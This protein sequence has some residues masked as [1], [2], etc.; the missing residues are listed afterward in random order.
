MEKMSA[1]LSTAALHE[2][3]NQRDHRDQKQEVNQEA[4]Y[5]KQKEAGYPR[6]Y[7]YGR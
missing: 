4:G 1:M 7:Q 6:Q 5:V 3:I 2:M